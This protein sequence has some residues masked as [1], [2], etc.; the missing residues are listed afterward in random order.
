MKGV[1]GLQEAGIL[2][3]DGAFF[4]VVDVFLELG[5]AVFAGV[6][7]ELVEHGEVFEVGGLGEGTSLE[8]AGNPFQDALE[9]GEGIGDHEGADGGAKYNDQLGGLEEDE[10]LSVLH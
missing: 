8:D 4:R 2:G 9:R 6:A 3:E 7:E 10:E 1:P 5:D